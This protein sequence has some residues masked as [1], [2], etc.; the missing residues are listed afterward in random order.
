ML[1]LTSERAP[2]GQA[3]DPEGDSV[4]I[5]HFLAVAAIAFGASPATAAVT[6]MVLTGFASGSDNGHVTAAAPFGST[7][8]AVNP[9]TGASIG[10]VAENF[11]TLTLRID[12]SLGA[13]DSF[14]D[15]DSRYGGGPQSPL[16]AT[17][18]LNG[19]S[20]DFGNL[21]S[22]FAKAFLTPDQI[23]GYAD[24]QRLRP[25]MT[26]AFTDVIGHLD[27]NIAFATQVFTQRSFG[28]P[29]SWI[30]GPGDV[31]AGALTLS[32]QDSTG[33]ELASVL[34]PVRTANLT[35]RFDTLT[36]AGV[37]EPA[38]W[39]LLIGGF[40]LAGAALRRNVRRGQRLA[41]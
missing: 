24:E 15:G 10:I 7:Q 36:I 16:A 5:I 32:L 31:S 26:G 25:P 20:Y 29:V 4:R 6:T 39:A 37:P 14:P 17:F 1:R 41:T 33:T 34:G 40:G 35:L 28:E 9:M 21:G 30:R 22:S 12:D 38:T 27:F 23:Y 3:V 2:A 18:S 8:F 11:F 19:Y 13:L